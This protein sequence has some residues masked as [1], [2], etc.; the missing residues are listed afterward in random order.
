R[1]LMMT[2]DSLDPASKKYDLV[3]DEIDKRFRWS[4]QEKIDFKFK[5]NL[6]A[7][8][9]DPDDLKKQTSVSNIVS[10]GV[11]AGLLST[12]IPMFGSLVGLLATMA[13]QTLMPSQ[14]K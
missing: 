9:I 7:K 11:Y 13:L 3:M 8:K 10:Q 6:Q 1:T 2:A 14:Q 4:D 12:A 5:E